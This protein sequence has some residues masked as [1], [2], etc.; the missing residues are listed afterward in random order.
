[1]SRLSVRPRDVKNARAIQ[2]FLAKAAGQNAVSRFK[3]GR[4]RHAAYIRLSSQ[5]SPQQELALQ[6][7]TLPEGL[8]VE[9][10]LS[11]LAYRTRDAEEGMQA[12]VEKRK[13]EFRD[14]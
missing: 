10:D 2:T 11:T 12:F 14:E 13:A 8:R 1:M 9:A 5:L 4:S 6:A 7:T 3:A